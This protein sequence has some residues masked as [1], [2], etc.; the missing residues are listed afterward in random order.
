MFIRFK[1]VW[2]KTM[3][4]AGNIM[5]IVP[6][7]RNRFMLISASV[8][9][10]VANLWNS[11]SVI[12][13]AFSNNKSWEFINNYSKSWSFASGLKHLMTAEIQTLGY[14]GNWIHN[15]VF[16]NANKPHYRE[17]D[18]TTFQSPN[19][20]AII[21]EGPR[22]RVGRLTKT[23]SF[24]EKETNINFDFLHNIFHVAAHQ[25]GQVVVI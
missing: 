17:W 24:G 7:P 22:N 6:H 19:Q 16:V 20:Y 2:S 25:N 12:R 8:W 14:R 10:E 9:T 5:K 18:R 15:A 4:R 23:W 3:R 11:Q 13:E 21:R 1:N